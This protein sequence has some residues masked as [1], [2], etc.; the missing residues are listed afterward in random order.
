[1]TVNTP[2]RYVYDGRTTIGHLLQRGEL[3]WEAFDRADQSLGM[4]ST[5][6]EAGNAVADAEPAIG[7]AA[8]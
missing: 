5:M 1:M 3:G 6:R 7:A 8:E 4:F 2:L